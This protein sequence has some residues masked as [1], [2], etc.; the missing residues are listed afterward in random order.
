MQRLKRILV[1]IFMAIFPQC[2]PASGARS[3]AN[4]PAHVM[5]LPSVH[6]LL[7]T[8]PAYGYQRLFDIVA[9]F[10]PDIVG[11]EI[12]QEDLSRSRDYL[13]R[14]Y[15]REMVDLANRYRDRIF[16]FDWLGDEL[17]GV[18][19]PADWWTKRSP[20][21]Q[22][23]RAW[24]ASA[25]PSDAGARSLVTQVEGLSSRR[26]ALETTASPEQLAT[27]P[28]NKITADYYATV[29]KLTAGTLYAEVPRWYAARDRHLDDV[30]L[31]KVVHNPGCRIVVVTGADHHGPMVAAIQTLAGKA[32]IEPIP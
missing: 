29:T 19:V 9:D 31:K 10:N 20:I 22:L 11:V 28:Y 3:C 17:R 13:S 23:E 2:A 6:K 7:A 12:R 27:G 8:N 5:V 26:D 16:G 30:V 15:P 24:E 25:T 14:V 4:G 21:K 32:V 18:P 1:A